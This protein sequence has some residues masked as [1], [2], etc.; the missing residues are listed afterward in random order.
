M[1]FS[2]VRE[3][4]IRGNV[5]PIGSVLRISEDQ[6]AKLGLYV[7]P[8]IDEARRLFQEVEVADPGGDCWQWIQHNRP[9]LWRS[10][11]QALH[12]D[13]IAVARM[14]FNQM[15]QVWQQR[16]QLNQPSLLTA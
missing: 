2:V 1:T 15:L 13:N 5:Q 3:F 14:T 12:A 16:H 10:H 11:I 6:A 9:D 8:L 4:K 7:K